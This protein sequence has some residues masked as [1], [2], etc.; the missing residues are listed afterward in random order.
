M[1]QISIIYDTRGGNTEKMAEAVAAGIEETEGVRYKLIPVEEAE[2]DDLLE[3]EGVIV[4]SPTHCG[5][6]TWKLK[7]FFDEH[8]GAAWGEVKGKIGAAFTTSGG[9]GGGNEMAAASILNVLI[10]YGFLVFGLPDYAA[11]EVTAHYGAV[12]VG[13]PNSEELKSCYILGEQTAAYVKKMQG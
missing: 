7:R 6:L 4:G 11:S 8:T 1:L 9:L 12:A 5:L 2:P 13:E 10:N 3:A